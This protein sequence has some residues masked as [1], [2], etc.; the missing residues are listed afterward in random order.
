MTP[1]T[2]NTHFVVA[3]LN[4]FASVLYVL[5]LNLEVDFID[6]L[7]LRLRLYEVVVLVSLYNKG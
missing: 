2:Y 7:P 1:T 5:F 4:L 6:I 3:V